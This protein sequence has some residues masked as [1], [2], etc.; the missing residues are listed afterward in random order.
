MTTEQQFHSFKEAIMN[1]EDANEAFNDQY[2]RA[3][4]A[5]TLAEFCTVVRDNFRWLVVSGVL[6]GE[7]IDAH[8]AIAEHGIRH[9]RDAKDGVLLVTGS[10]SVRASGTVSV[11]AR[12][13]S[14]VDA[15]DRSTVWAMQDSTVNARRYSFV[16]ATGNSRVRAYGSSIVRAGD[17]STVEAFGDSTVEAIGRVKVDAS[18]HSK[19]EAWDGATVRASGSSYVDVLCGD[20]ECELSAQ[21]VLRQGNTIRTK[22]SVLTIS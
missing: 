14:I 12:G 17:N 3:Y 8:P 15:T 16:G 21:A 5:N 10:A 13:H 7:L 18:G 4:N 6:T 19:V 20:I 2:Y 1:G 9:N 22:D 11:I